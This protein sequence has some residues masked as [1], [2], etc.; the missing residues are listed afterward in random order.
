MLKEQGVLC[1]YEDSVRVSLELSVVVHTYNPSTGRW[2]QED[3]KSKDS[4]G[5]IAKPCLRKPKIKNK[6]DFGL[7]SQV[8]LASN[9]SL[10]CP[11]YMS[12]AYI[13]AVF[14]Q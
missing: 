14:D 5:Y 4:L 12:K 6:N 7:G 10:P 2:R 9:P 8:P 11:S 1:S 13:L 3:Y